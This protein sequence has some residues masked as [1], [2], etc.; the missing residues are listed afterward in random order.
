ML[1]A[2]AA[3]C[4]AV[5]GPQGVRG[6]AFLR[7]VREALPDADAELRGLDAAA[8]G[9]PGTSVP[10]RRPAGATAAPPALL[11]RSGSPEPALLDG[12]ARARL[13]AAAPT[14]LRRLPGP[15]PVTARAA[16]AQ[17]GWPRLA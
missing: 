14:V 9:A 4:G 2:L 10:G 6:E 7:Q 5:G 3:H 13:A 17:T 15:S 11:A 16:G 1:V 8:G 12:R